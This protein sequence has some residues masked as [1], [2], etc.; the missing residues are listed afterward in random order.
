MT[1][2][3]FIARHKRIRVEKSVILTQPTTCPTD[4]ARLL[5]GVTLLSADFSPS[6]CQTSWPSDLPDWFFWVTGKERCVRSRPI[7]GCIE[8]EDLRP[9]KQRPR[10]R[11]SR[12]RRPRKQKKLKKKT[13]AEDLYKGKGDTWREVW[14]E[15]SHLSLQALSRPCSFISLLSFWRRRTSDNTG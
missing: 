7:A 6:D 9:R 8:N 11:Q 3:D 2:I 14:L 15:V 4:K 1:K 10:K 13:W 12:K 5:S